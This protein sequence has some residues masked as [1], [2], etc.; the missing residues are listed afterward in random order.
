MFAALTAVTHRRPGGG[1]PRELLLLRGMP[2]SRCFNRAVVRGGSGGGGRWT[3]TLVPTLVRF[4]S[5]VYDSGNGGRR[6]PAV[7]SGSGAAHD[8][9]SSISPPP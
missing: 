2:F 9:A 6:P 1:T 5:P 7:A 4:P 3:R 8:G